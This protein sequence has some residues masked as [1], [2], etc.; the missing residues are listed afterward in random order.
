M[1][2][3]DV[4]QYVIEVGGVKVEVTL[5]EANHCPGAVCILFAFANGKLVLH[6]GDF[7]WNGGR[8]LS[9]SPTY[10]A[11]AAT[12]ATSNPR[13][14]VVYLDTTYCEAEHNFPPQSSVVGFPC[15]RTVIPCNHSLSRLIK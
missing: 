9:L 6:T 15:L 2:N 4:L 13:N 11:L 1:W 8:L 5:L 3:N 14:L 7:R 12:A 10:R